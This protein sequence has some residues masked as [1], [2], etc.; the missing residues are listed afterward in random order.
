MP[1]W[2]AGL[3]STTRHR[4]RGGQNP[5][6]EIHPV[7]LKQRQTD[8]ISE[9]LIGQAKTPDIALSRAQGRVKYGF[10]LNAGQ[11]LTDTLRVFG[12]LG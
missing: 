9:Y 6:R 2:R 4:A 7:L 11:E 12:R 10:G 3:P 1:R 5:E 8:A